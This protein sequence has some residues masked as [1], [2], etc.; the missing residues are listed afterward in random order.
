MSS[1][2]TTGRLAGRLALVTGASRGLGAAVAKR[3]AAEGAHVVLVARTVGG[4]EAVDDAIRAAGGPAP[5]LVPA[6]LRKHEALEVLGASLYQ[7]FGKLDIVVGNAAQLGTLS[8]IA[9]SELKPWTQTIELNLIAN[10]RLIRAM[11]P[12]LRQSDAG[13]A[14]FVTDSV[15]H[16]P[17]PYWNAYAVSKSGLET[18]VKLYAAENTKTA[19]RAN[20]V[21]PGPL[22]TALRAKAYPGETGEALPSP[23]SV[24]DLFVR[25]AEPSCTD[26]GRILTPADL[27]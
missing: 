27:G 6:D 17:K 11:D 14:I 5:T 9:H 16:G 2:S 3:F 8:P 25:L 1:P 12:L 23:D 26:T 20:L 24:A 10:Y 4:L 18:L 19:I 21:D 7:R 22:A 13:R 15:A